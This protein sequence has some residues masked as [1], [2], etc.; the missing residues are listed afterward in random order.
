MPPVEDTTAFWDSSFAA[1][2][3]QTI[4]SPA[5]SRMSG[6][7]VQLAWHYTPDTVGA[8]YSEVLTDNVWMHAEIG[9]TNDG[10]GGTSVP[11]ASLKYLL[12]TQ[13]NRCKT[14]IAHAGI[15]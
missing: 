8:E 7:S 13:E 3:I 2:P 10:T 15:C 14:P 6:E 1:T 12:A 5:I 11:P 9:H 4:R